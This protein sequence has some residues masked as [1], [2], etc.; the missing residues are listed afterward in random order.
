VTKR[1]R[2]MSQASKEK[3][4]GSCNLCLG[5]RGKTLKK[6]KKRWSGENIRGV[7]G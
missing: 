1:K 2:E 7:L 3:Q 4:R 5:V 6:E